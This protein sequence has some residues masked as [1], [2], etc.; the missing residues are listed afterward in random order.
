LSAQE[1][2]VL[3]YLME[4]DSNKIITRETDI[5]EATVKVHIKAILPKIQVHHRTQAA[6][7]AMHNGSFNGAAGNGLERKSAIS[8]LWFARRH[9][10]AE[11]FRRAGLA[12]GK[13]SDLPRAPSLRLPLV[14]FARQRLFLI[15]PIG[16][17]R[18]ES[19]RAFVHRH[20]RPGPILADLGSLDD[21]QKLGVRSR[22]IAVALH[23]IVADQ[24]NA[25]WL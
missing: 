4:G 3:H 24:K 21:L 22:Q 9:E 2:R 14:L 13:T 20:N 18:L 12:A 15:A 19:V 10:C 25:P 11:A 23:A 16:E 8:V 6:I 1:K 7:W 17:F 5:A